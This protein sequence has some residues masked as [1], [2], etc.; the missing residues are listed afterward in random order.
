MLT[1]RDLSPNDQDRVLP[2]VMDFYQSEAVDQLVD[3][4]L[5]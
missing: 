5:M 3:R 2:M 4:A 1:F